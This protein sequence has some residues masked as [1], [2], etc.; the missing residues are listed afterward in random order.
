MP[1]MLG[2]WRE[3]E[4]IVVKPELNSSRYGRILKAVCSGGFARLLSSAITLLSLPLAVRYLGA[5]RY[6]IWATVTTTA[7]WINLL[8]IGIAN[9]LTNQISRAYALGDKDHAARYLTSALA[10]SSGMAALG[11]FA[12]AWLI[13]RVDW[14]RLLN[15]SAKVGAAEVTHTV[16][17]AVALM[18]LALPCNLSS[19]VLAGYQELHLSNYAAGAGAVASW[20]G[21]ALGVVLHVSMPVLFVMS[22]G[23][24][25]LAN[26]VTLLAVVAFQKPWLLPHPSLVERGALQELLSS[27]SSFFLIQV[28]AV[29][30][31]SS[32]NLI[33]SHYLGAFEV[34]PYSV[35]WRVVGFVALVPSLVFPAL[36]PAYAEAY[37]KHDYA[38][39]RRTFA[40]TMTGTVALNA[41]CVSGLLL[42]GRGLI[43]LWAG[44]AAV[45][46]WPLLLTMCLWAL[47]SGFM[48]VESCLLAALNRTRAQALLSIVAAGLNVALSVIWVHRIGSLGVIAGTIVSYLVVLVLPQTLIVRDLWKNELAAPQ[49]TKPVA[50]AIRASGSLLRSGL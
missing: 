31:F 2:P 50:E 18:L 12:A 3:R 41:L 43:R 37:A 48:T 45:P 26:L 7:V 46:N 28:A 23:C 49:E 35:T 24:L 9:T 13:P 33:V 5:E 47:I 21:L 40:M 32:D 6:G 4:H 22:A 11:G 42:F 10:L 34:T 1:R 14:A 8:D 19:K 39:I 27:G 15:A 30:V 38:W 36:W 17:V 16:A 20:C 25:P 44:A 29:V